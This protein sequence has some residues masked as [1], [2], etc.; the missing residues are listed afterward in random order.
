MGFCALKLAEMRNISGSLAAGRESESSGPGGVAGDA[1]CPPAAPRG[2]GWLQVEVALSA[3]ARAGRRGR[4]PVRPSPSK[5]GRRAVPSALN[6]KGMGWSRMTS[7]AGP[8][9]GTEGGG[10][11]MPAAAFWFCWHPFSVRWMKVPFP[12]SSRLPLDPYEKVRRQTHRWMSL[13]AG[14]VRR[15]G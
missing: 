12:P 13:A 3:A 11:L 7:L 5:A 9:T 2:A 6:L 14:R 10:G 8:G 15:K 4:A 1:G